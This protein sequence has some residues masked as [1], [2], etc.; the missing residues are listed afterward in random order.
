[1]LF[2][3]VVDNYLKYQL[4]MKSASAYTISAYRKDL[5]QSFPFEQEFSFSSAELLNFAKRA[6]VSWSK[7]AA[8]SRNRK[9]ST[10]KSFFNYLFREGLIDAEIALQLTSPKVPIKLPHYIS[11]DEV[12]S[13]LQFLKA[14]ENQNS[15]TH[16]HTQLLFLLL[17]GSGLRISEAAKL[18]I[19]DLNLNQR[20][21]LVLGKGGT[22]RLAVLPQAVLPV[23]KMIF[24]THDGPFVWGASALNSRT[25][26]EM[27]KKL[28]RSA[29]LRAPLNPHALRHS[30]ATHLL[31]S[32]ANLRTLQSL[33]G[34]QSLT[35]TQKYTHLSLDELARTLESKSPIRISK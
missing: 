27:I 14:P 18:K 17:Y 12:L 6:Q 2:Q 28:G 9:V 3:E 7:L 34:H 19:S 21:A 4:N 23:F 10:L 16:L 22:E 20:T 1:M 33:L 30:F 25:G 5:Q 15:T 24:A 26:H 11:V 32:G 31:S 8:S 29:Q 13:I 35:A